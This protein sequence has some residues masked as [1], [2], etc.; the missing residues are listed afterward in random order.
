[1]RKS[2]KAIRCKCSLYTLF[3][4]YLLFGE[5]MKATP[6]DSRLSSGPPKLMIRNSPSNIYENASAWWAACMH[7]IWMFPSNM[8][9]CNCIRLAF[10]SPSTFQDARCR[11]LSHGYMACKS[12]WDFGCWRVSAAIGE[13]GNAIECETPTHRRVSYFD[14]PLPLLFCNGKLGTNF[15]NER[16]Q[17]WIVETRLPV[18]SPLDVEHL[19]IC[20]GMDNLKIINR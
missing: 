19:T 10:V 4:K 17:F 15:W 6:A 8:M 18:L 12:K 7:N 16:R 5:I 20:R 13:S 11:S 2:R 3:I 14:C 1:M 9:L